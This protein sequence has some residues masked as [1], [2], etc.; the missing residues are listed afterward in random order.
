MDQNDFYD[1]CATQENVREKGTCEV[2][3]SHLPSVTRHR[4]FLEAK[5]CTI[6]FGNQAVRL[7]WTVSTKIQKSSMRKDANTTSIPSWIKTCAFMTCLQKWVVSS[8]SSL[9]TGMNSLIRFTSLF[10]R[11]IFDSHSFCIIRSLCHW[12]VSARTVQ[13]NCPGLCEAL[14]FSGCVRVRMVLLRK[15]VGILH[16]TLLPTHVPLVMLCTLDCS[17]S[18]PTYHRISSFGTSSTHCKS[19]DKFFALRCFRDEHHTM[20]RTLLDH[21]VWN[22]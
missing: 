13:M 3:C 4:Y 6:F 7:S 17:E 8:L 16:S 11:T 21:T 2:Y 19:C 12:S 1:A 15:C 20:G 9:L 22:P 18:D 10:I 5:S 14:M